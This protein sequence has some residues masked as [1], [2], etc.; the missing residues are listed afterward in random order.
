MQLLLLLLP[1]LLWHQP[2]LQGHGT[3]YNRT[4]DSKLK[5]VDCRTRDVS[6]C[7]TAERAILT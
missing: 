6:D 3:W 2:K 7:R 5:T 4:T 1:R